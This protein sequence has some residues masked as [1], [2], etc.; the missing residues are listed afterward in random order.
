MKLRD[1]VRAIALAACVAGCS[2]QR[3]VPRRVI[4]VAASGD[5]TRAED[6]GAG[7]DAPP[8][9]A[10]AGPCTATEADRACLSAGIA[11]LGQSAPEAH[12]EE[13]PARAARLRAFEIDRD[14]VSA[15][16]Y[17]ACVAAGTCRA[18]TCDEGTVPTVDGAARCVAWRDAR[19]F[20]ATRHGRLPTEA[21]WE[22]A[23]AGLLPLHR[24]YPWGDD[25]GAGDAEAPVDETPEGVRGLGGG[26][27]EWVDDVGAFYIAPRRPDAGSDASAD[28][29][30]RDASMDAS[31]A[32]G[33][34]NGT[35]Q[36]AFT[37]AGVTEY[38]EAGL[39]IIDDPRG[40]RDG[41]WRVVRGGDSSAPAT[42]WTSA[43]RRFRV[44]TDRRAWI[45][46]RCAY[47]R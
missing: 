29:D 19:V 27:A 23:A 41:T 31:V 25:A 43:G 28:A 36:Q 13:R 17:A 6:G 40:P 22:R 10:S 46:F 24:T 21:E 45:G 30:M 44:P 18:M 8:T 32:I 1:G 3:T 39:A 5:V 9:T 42:R 2:A 35:S 33:D 11:Q 7:A 37:D 47:D 16:A 38:T 26:V 20:C 12:F 34:A 4:E 15:E 14:E